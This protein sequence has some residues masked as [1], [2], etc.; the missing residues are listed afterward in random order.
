MTLVPGSGSIPIRG[1]TAF[2]GRPNLTFGPD[3]SGPTPRAH[4]ADRRGLALTRSTSVPG[5]A[6]RKP[7]RAQRDGDY[8][9]EALPNQDARTRS[10]WHQRAHRR[11]RLLGVRAGSAVGLWQGSERPAVFVVDHR[12]TDLERPQRRRDDLGILY[13]HPHLDG[14][15]RFVARSLILATDKRPAKPRAV[16]AKSERSLL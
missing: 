8:H 1:W 12:R 11:Q 15:R 7:C 3:K 2:S 13:G 5:S 14:Q 6:D 9:R 16:P 4:R 10:L